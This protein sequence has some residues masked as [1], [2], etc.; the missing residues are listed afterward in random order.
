MRRVR[1][2]LLDMMRNQVAAIPESAGGTF[3]ARLIEEVGLM[4]EDPSRLP[5]QEG[6]PTGMVAALEPSRSRIEAAWSPATDRFELAVSK[7]RG[8]F[9]VE[10][11]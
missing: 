5:W 2:N 4:A 8:K 11:D 1:A 9:S 10:V 3:R 6:L 7:R